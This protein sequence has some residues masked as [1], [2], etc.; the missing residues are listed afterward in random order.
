[1]FGVVLG[2]T[3]AILVLRHLNA[4]AKALEPAEPAD[5]VAPSLEPITCNANYLDGPYRICLRVDGSLWSWSARLS[6]IGQQQMP[7]APV[8]VGGDNITLGSRDAALAAAWV[9][10]AKIPIGDRVVPAP[11]DTHGLTLASSG[12]VGLSSLAQYLAWAPN[13]IAKLVAGLQAQNAAPP[14]AI[15]VFMHVMY[16]T[17]GRNAN[18]LRMRVAGE[19]IATTIAR[20]E[21]DAVKSSQSQAE[22]IIRPLMP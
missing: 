13:Q 1:M 14:D 15:H 21:A 3:A 4:R 9:A 17:F 2:V 10:L 7:D 19:P 6:A 11:V 12:Y 16:E 22:A 8:D 18:P 20:I 5:P